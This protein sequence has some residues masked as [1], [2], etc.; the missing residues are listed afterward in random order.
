MDRVIPFST[1]RITNPYGN[2]H[3]GVDLGYRQDEEMNKVYP[4][5]YGEV[6]EVQKN[7]PHTPGSRLWGNYVLIKHTNGWHTRYCHLQ[8]NIRVNVGDIVDESTWI[9]TIGDSG[10]A[11]F[12]HLHYEVQTEYSSSTRIDPT[13]YLVTPISQP[14]EYKIKYRGHVQGVGWQ[15]WVGDGELAGTTARNLRLEALQIDTSKEVKAK[16]HIEG[17]GWKDF[18]TINKDTIIGTVG[19]SRR[20]ECIC[21]EGDFKYRVHI[22]DTGWSCWTKADGIATLGSVGQ[23][24]KIEGIE[25]E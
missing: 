9:A 15:T 16:A 12:R 10:D 4:N 24:L 19:E 11:E 18:G 20:L 13:P 3:N 25:I 7:Q 2:G 22:Q 23:E 17:I 5:S 6:V 21:L 14:K 1:D 8:N